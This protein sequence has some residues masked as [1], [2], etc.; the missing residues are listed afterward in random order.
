MVPALL[1]ILPLVLAG[2]AGADRQEVPSNSPPGPVPY[3]INYQG[4]LLHDTGAPINDT[5]DLTFG[6]WRDPGDPIAVWEEEHYDV[7]VTNGHF[8]LAVR[9]ISAIVSD[10]GKIFAFN[11]P[12]RG[13]VSNLPE[14]A[15]V[16]V[17]GTVDRMGAHSFAMGP[18]PRNCLGINTPWS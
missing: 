7:S 17:T 10:L 5:V 6:S 8:D 4:R 18:C 2:S 13:A 9:V 12:N 1:F 3:F 16:D 14:D 11:V 15:I